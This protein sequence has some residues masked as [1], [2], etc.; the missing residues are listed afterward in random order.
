MVIADQ[1]RAGRI[2]SRPVTECGTEGGYRKH[3]RKG[4]NACEQCKQAHTIYRRNDRR[5]T[6]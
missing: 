4:Q 2:V 1:I 6:V 3:L 5:M